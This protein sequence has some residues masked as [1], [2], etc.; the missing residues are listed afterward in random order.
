MT[1]LGV[2]LASLVGLAVI[3]LR[4]LFVDIGPVLFHRQSPALTAVLRALP[5]GWA[6]VAVRGARRPVG[7]GWAPARPCGAH[8]VLL[9]AWAPLLRRR[10]TV[11]SVSAGPSKRSSRA[12]R[13][14]AERSL[15]PIGAVF[16]RELRLWWRD[17][18]RRIVLITSVL[19]G[20]VIPLFYSAGGGRSLVPY[21]ALW[22]TVFATMQMGNLYGIDG[23]SLWH[24]LVTP[25]AARADVRGRQ[26]A[27][28]A[29]IAPLGVLAA[30]LAPLVV[31]SR[32]AYP[33]L[34][35]LV[36]VLLGSGAGLIV[37]Q[38]AL[39]PFALPQQRNQN[40]FSSVSAG[41]GPGCIRVLTALAYLLL[42][43]P[44]RLPS[45]SSSSPAS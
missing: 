9:L 23:G 35:G 16:V 27:W 4:Y 8:G 17:A 5:S 3:P 14:G 19:L 37:M 15:G 30:V 39:L 31:G 11:V 22:L 45:L 20:I 28:L 42:L 40:P 44:A 1:D 13:R 6:A 32:S 29:I 18:R 25:G 7:S 33:W 34:A 10:L 12:R 21:L 2:L 43:A 26:V 36:P 38:S 24:V 41:S